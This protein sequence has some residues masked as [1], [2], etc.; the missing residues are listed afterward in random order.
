MVKVSPRIVPPNV[1]I[2][3]DAKK[4][5]EYYFIADNGKALTHLPL[6]ASYEFFTI[7]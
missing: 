6:R 1:F 2:D 7:E 4:G 3:F 5:G